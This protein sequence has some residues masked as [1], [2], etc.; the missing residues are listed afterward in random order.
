MDQYLTQYQVSNLKI[1][2][3]GSLTLALKIDDA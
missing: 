2:A 1:L 3:L